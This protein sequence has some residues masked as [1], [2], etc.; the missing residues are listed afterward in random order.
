M[1]VDLYPKVHRRYS[2][3]AIIGPILD[4]YGTWLLKQGYSTERACAHFRAAP[5][6][7]RGLQ[8]RG[9]QALTSLAMPVR[10]FRHVVHAKSTLWPNGRPMPM[11]PMSSG[12][13]LHPATAKLKLP[14]GLHLRHG[15]RGRQQDGRECDR[16]PEAGGGNQPGQRR[17]EG[18][19]RGDSHGD[20]L[21]MECVGRVWLS[22][23]DE[24]IPP[25]SSHS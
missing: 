10:S 19:G 16:C 14:A 17:G 2:S 13:E 20:L 8:Q 1:L 4:G 25:P 24:P 5:R 6:L 12:F 15:G 18:D 23:V 9:V 7:V 21:A 11:S 3:L 22:R